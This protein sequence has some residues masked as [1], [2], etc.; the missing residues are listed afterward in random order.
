VMDPKTLAWAG[1]DISKLNVGDV[2]SP[3]DGSA[4]TSA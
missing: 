3:N 4:T 2:A 1:G